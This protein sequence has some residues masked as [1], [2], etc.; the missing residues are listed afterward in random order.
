LGVD[1]IIEASLQRAGNH[2]RITVQLIR[3]S[4]DAHLWAKDYDRD[5]SDVLKLESDVSQSV[6]REIRAQITPS[7]AR[8][9]VETRRVLP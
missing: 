4:D 7:E 6:A 8:R 3:A 5:L 9:L 2:V 1:A